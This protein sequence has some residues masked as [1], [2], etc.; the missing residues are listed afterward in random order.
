MEG[1]KSPPR[2][3]SGS[4]NQAFEVRAIHLAA[5]QGRRPVP[6]HAGVRGR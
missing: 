3:S 4:G 5:G 2:L 1:A 6:E